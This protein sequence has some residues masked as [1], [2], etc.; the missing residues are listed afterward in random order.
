MVF[1][2]AIMVII[3]LSVFQ[4]LIGQDVKKIED[5]LQDIVFLLEEIWFHGKVRNKM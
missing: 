1:C 3:K 2:I 5:P 4:M